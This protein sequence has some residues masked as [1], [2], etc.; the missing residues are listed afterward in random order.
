[1]LPGPPIRVQSAPLGVTF[2]G[3]AQLKAKPDASLPITAIA[4]LTQSD[5]LGFI[6]DTAAGGTGWL[7]AGTTP[8]N[9]AAMLESAISEFLSMFDPLR[10]FF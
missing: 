2:P 3:S 5:Q 4:E 8:K 6:C 10:P 1:V 9:A 7:L